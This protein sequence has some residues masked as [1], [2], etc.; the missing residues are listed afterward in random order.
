MA[1][2]RVARTMTNRTKIAYFAGDYHGMFDE[3]LLRP[4]NSQ[5]QFRSMP[6]A[7]GLPPLSGAEVLILEY[8]SPASLEI[9]QA[10]AHELAAVLVE[11][12]QSR[13][14]DLQPKEFLHELRRLTE[15]SGTV[16]I[17]DE[18]I[19][20]FRVAPGGAQ[21][22][23][24]V[25]PDVST[26][27]KVVGGGFPIGVLAGKAACLD[28]LDGGF[29][30]YGDDSAPEADMTFFA[31]T[32]V[33]HPLALAAAKASLLHLKERG[34]ALQ[35]ELNERTTAMV[36]A[37]DEIMARHHAPIRVMHFGSLFRFHF[38]A[39][40]P[41]APLF[42][43][44]MV[45]Q[46][47]YL[48]EAHQNCFL[49]TAHTAEDVQRIIHAVE[50]TVS[51]L[52]AA[53]LLP[54]IDPHE[55][56]RPG[57]VSTASASSAQPPVCGDRLGAGHQT[58]PESWPLTEAQREIWL[59]A[60]LGPDASCAFNESCSVHLRGPL[61]HEA[62]RRA[63]TEVV[64]R[65]DALRTVFDPDGPTQRLVTPSPDALPLSFT[66]LSSLP[67]DEREKQLGEIHAQN[68]TTPFD[69]VTG[70]LWRV[71][72]V[73][74]AEDR[75]VLVFTAHHIICDGWSSAVILAELGQSYSAPPGGDSD[76]QKPARQFSEFAQ[77]Q[78][79][80]LHSAMGQEDETWWLQQFPEPIPVLD[81]PEDAAG[82]G[83]ESRV[84]PAGWAR[85]Q[86]SGELLKSLQRA[87][88]TQGVTMFSLLFAGFNILLHRLSGQDEIAVGVFASG[89][90]RLGWDDLVGHCVSMLPI[91][92]CVSG[93]PAFPEYL[94]ELKGRL[95]DAHE[96][97]GYTYGQL[98]Q[99]L[100]LA[101]P[102]DRAPL[103]QAV[104]NLERQGDE[105]LRFDGLE[106]AIDQNPHRFV[107]FDL[108]LNIRTGPD[109]LS[110]DLEYNAARF[111]AAA[112]QRWLGHYETLLTGLTR[113][114]EARVDELPLLS[115]TERQQLLVEWNTSTTP[116]ARE[117]CL[118]Q[119]FEEQAER[120]PDAI[121]V[122]GPGE[123]WTYRELRERAA[124]VAARLRTA[125]VGPDSLVALCAERSPAMIAGLLGI[126]QAGG[127]YVPLD[128][129]YPQERLA[130]ILADSRA[131]V[132]LAS[133]R[134]RDRLPPAQ[135][136]QAILD[137]DEDT[138]SQP[139]P[140]SNGSPEAGSTPGV[141]PRQLA[142]VIYTSGST[143]QPKGVAIEHRNAAAFVDWAH[144][145]F[146]P[147]EL[148][149]VLASTSICFDLSIF[150]LFVPLTSGGTVI[151][152]E[153]ILQ[154]AGLP[155][156]DAVTLI[157][158]VP[159]AMTELLRLQAVPPSVRTI[160]LA[161]EPLA[162][163]LVRQLHELPGVERVYDLYGPS[164]TT[165]YST[166]ALRE[167]DGP[168]TIGRPIA[169]TQIYLLDAGRQPVPIGVAG[170]VF[171]AGAGVA[172]GYLHRPE[173]T[174]EKFFPDPF[175]HDDA[176]GRV[177]R[178]GDR[179]RFLDDGNIQFLGRTDQQ[180]K[181]RG[182]RIEL[183]EIENV[184]RQHPRVQDGAVI[185]APDRSNTPQLVAYVAARENPPSS[186]DAAP[187]GDP[188]AEGSW[189]K[190]V[191]S[192]FDSG[193]AAAIRETQETSGDAPDPTHDP[194][195]NIYGWSGL[196]KT[197][198]E[199]ARWIEQIATRLLGLRPQRLLEIGCGT[200]LVL[201][202][203]APHVG[204]YWATDL[205]RAAIDH[206]EQ[207]AQNRQGRD[208]NR[209]G[210]E[211]VK[212]FCRTADDFEG[213]PAAYFDGVIL[214]AVLEYFP[215]TDYL[216]KVLQGVIGMVKRGGFIF[217]GA[218]PN[219]AV[220]EVFHAWD[221]LGRAD[222]HEDAATVLAR[223]A[224]RLEKDTRLLVAPEFFQALLPELPALREIR[225]QML[226]D[227]F[228]NEASKLIADTF[229]D[230]LLKVGDPAP[231]AEN[232]TPAVQW[233]DWRTDRRSEVEKALEELHREK[234]GLRAV[235]IRGVP[236]ERLQ[237]RWQAL[238][239]WSEPALTVGE[240][241]RRLASS[242]P[243]KALAELL[244][245]GQELSLHAE[246]AWSGNGAAG[247]CD[248]LFSRA[249]D[250][251]PGVPA[252]PI[253]PADRATFL[254]AAASHP[255]QAR[256]AGELGPELRAFLQAKLPAHMIP[257][258]FVLLDKLPRTPNG[259]LDRRALPAPRLAPRVSEKAY[260]PPQSPAEIAIAQIWCE[261]LKLKQVGTQDD[262]FDLGGHSLLVTQ[263]A[264][265]LR[266]A[267][268]V[269]FPIRWLF[270]QPTIAATAIGIEKLL[271]EQVQELSEE[272]AA[273]LTATS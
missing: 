243:G 151:L 25:Q 195:L 116:P 73:R 14:P 168:A 208:G 51:E 50:Q 9:L 74:L 177:Y 178:T 158:T 44:L 2:L 105:G 217:L 258:A 68:A 218:V 210:K 76:L 136:G 41:F 86:L 141:T 62:L 18:V 113:N 150:E 63:W 33:R 72:L 206:L 79:E 15:Q 165:T 92:S 191:A 155:D 193:Y 176:T 233:L 97:S 84:A 21:A 143:G 49:S 90:S 96:H 11:P 202:R 81:L 52:R 183:G 102:A 134:L 238:E 263:V 123:R 170:E 38:P 194:T 98:L 262:F 80:A 100:P 106:L 187:A 186:S 39:D 94:K 236:H 59:A 6:V 126:L 27:G 174:A 87:A 213:M 214:N 188:P 124:T 184:L 161:G 154:L 180:V 120:T 7:P 82:P 127:A 153:N 130:F 13:H 75:H 128:P 1:A 229:Y 35:E 46:G 225:F 252:Q 239:Q 249:H 215:D 78:A 199:V 164:E 32:F 60:Q 254:H 54:V 259:K 205:S 26:Y 99:K 241:R 140:G 260:H 245:D 146:S 149:G 89:Q 203:L 181:L 53:E 147:Q 29:W 223:A 240:L 138:N 58:Q 197:E 16:L 61:D 40:W 261:V 167:P 163:D 88:A 95:L 111:S 189:L 198:E 237:R 220:Q 250:A 185:I 19:T 152:A 104:F 175:R 247:C 135:P 232:P 56:S 270:E 156:R 112:I 67:D 93:R 166:F 234:G 216:R 34:P 196:K 209:S 224:A 3:V 122:I 65:H 162:P 31:G 139:G 219:F 103:V 125:G 251:E 37:I 22:I 66:D 77:A 204:E 115:A 182:F 160:N 159:S 255:L 133:S 64:S 201:A 24:G 173:L 107:L 145:V 91:R 211:N 57:S 85:V 272:D 30:Q 114:H 248:V 266:D 55:C 269:D 230:V 119:L 8:G 118:H 227:H 12:V 273:R 101:R 235:G 20:G 83:E 28:A 131:H 157:N 4:N 23:F 207:R 256:L 47:I 121:A 148:S 48:R 257:A 253:A 142:Y 70:P 179:A 71:Q 43:Y 5:G 129:A 169:G 36:H 221:Q 265:R 108:F 10:H 117:A 110:L 42:I 192:Q 231:G 212:L 264:A 244:R 137:L 190:E 17:F 172:R 132:V 271:V 228:E 222:E 226:S 144:R 268:Q 267:F 171:I 246:L 69:L 242:E 200:G 45:E 109:A